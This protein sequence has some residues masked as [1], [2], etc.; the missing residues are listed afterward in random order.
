MANIEIK[1][2]IGSGVGTDGIAEYSFKQFVSEYAAA[3]GEPIRLFIN[4]I[5]G[6]PFE[7]D[8]ISDFIQAN[9]KSFLSVSNSGV[10]AS[11]AV[12]CFL[13]LPFEKRYYNIQNGVALMHFPFLPELTG[14]EFTA[15]LLAQVSEHMKAKGSEMAKFYAKQTG[16]ELSVIE[17]LMAI[18]EPL[19]ESQLESINFANII[20]FKA[21]AYFNN[22]NKNDEMKKEEMEELLETRDKNLFEKIVA[23]FKP[24]MKAVM[25]TTSTGEQIDFPDTPEGSDVQVG[26]SVNAPDGDLLMADGSTIVVVAGKVS[27]IKPKVEDEPAA[28]EEVEALKAEIERLKG[29]AAGYKA[30]ADEYAGIKAQLSKIQSKMEVEEKEIRGEGRKQKSESRL[31]SDFKNKFKN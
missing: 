13:S 27:E 4:S 18:N 28:N 6:D 12:K 29:E 7:S 16:A 15:E 22:N 9:E 10:V 2:V 19:T 1:G 23:L 31:S 8:K 14:A 25:L 20:K 11:A 24:K 3:K 26:D 21:V 30:E 5:G 17:A